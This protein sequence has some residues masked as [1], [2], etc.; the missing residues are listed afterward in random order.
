MRKKRHES[1]RAIRWQ[2]TLDACSVPSFS[3]V[4]KEVLGTYKFFKNGRIDL[5]YSLCRG[6]RLILGGYYVPSVN[7]GASP[8]FNHPLQLILEIM[9]GVDMVVHFLRRIYYRIL[10]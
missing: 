8:K 2:F 10:R 6:F 4:E 7:D 1:S 5:Y 9:E 3:H